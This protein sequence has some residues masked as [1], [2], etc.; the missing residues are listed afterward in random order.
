[1]GPIFNDEYIVALVVSFTFLFVYR[2][3]SLGAL[4]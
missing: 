4:L 2:L 3:K 1:M